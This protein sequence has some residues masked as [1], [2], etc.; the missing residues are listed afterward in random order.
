[1]RYVA[2]A[3]E[4]GVLEYGTPLTTGCAGGTTAD[5]VFGQGGSFTS[6]LCNNGGLSAN[7]LCSPRHVALDGAGN[8]Y[9]ADTDNN[10]VLEYDTPLNSGTTAERHIGRAS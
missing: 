8:L 4:E 9:V 6:N 1:M 5:R 10:R 3:G 7:S 2:D